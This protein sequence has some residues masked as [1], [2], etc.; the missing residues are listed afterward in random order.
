MKVHDPPSPP[1]F[2][3]K[4]TK[5]LQIKCLQVFVFCNYE[6]F[7]TGIRIILVSNSVSQTKF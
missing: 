6:L 7:Y 1:I 3:P 4:M 5:N 2:I